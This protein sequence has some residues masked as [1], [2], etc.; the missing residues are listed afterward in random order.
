MGDI[1]TVF[2]ILQDQ[3]LNIHNSHTHPDAVRML[4]AEALEQVDEGRRILALEGGE[5]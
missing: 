3:L 5:A 2:D 1:A 4:V